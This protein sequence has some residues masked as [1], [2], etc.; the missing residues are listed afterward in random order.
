MKFLYGI[1]T[2]T[3]LAASSIVHAGFIKSSDG[4]KDFGI[5]DVQSVQCKIKDVLLLAKTSDDCK[6]AGGEVVKQ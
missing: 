2:L 6:N 5:D 1:I 3:I 4:K